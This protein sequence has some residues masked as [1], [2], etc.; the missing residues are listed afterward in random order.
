MQ[1]ITVEITKIQINID[2]GLDHLYCDCNPDKALC[3][4][5]LTDWEFKEDVEVGCVVCTAME[6]LPC[7]ICGW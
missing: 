2:D 3:G 5:D 4:T 6:Y 1:T 7:P